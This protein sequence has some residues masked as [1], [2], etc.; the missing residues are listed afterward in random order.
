M[1]IYSWDGN[2]QINDEATFAAWFV[3][4]G[5]GLP[6]ME[7][8]LVGRHGAHPLIGGV[9]RQ[10]LELLF[11]VEVL[12][13]SADTLRAWFDSE[14]ETPKILVVTDDDGSNARYW[15]ALCV[16]FEATAVPYIYLVRLRVHG[17][18]RPRAVA[19][20]SSSWNVTSSGATTVIA[21]GTA[22]ANDN[23]YPIVTL[24]P[25]AYSVGANSYRRFITVR[26]RATSSASGYPVDITNDGLDTRVASTNFASATGA[27][28][29]VYVDGADTDFWLDGIDT[30]TTKIF[31]TLN[32]S[33]KQATTL[34]TGV[35]TG[36]L[37]S[38]SA[39]SDISGFPGSGILEIGSE[40]FVYTGKDNGTRT[41]SGVTRAAKG[42]TAASHSTGAAISWIQHD[43][44]IEYGSASLPSYTIG[45]T[46]DQ[47][48][49]DLAT[50][51][52]TSW[53][54]DDFF[55]SE[56]DR[57]GAWSFSNTKNTAAYGGNRTA[58]ATTYG[59]MGI[60]S[61][62]SGTKLS[63]DGSWSLFNPCGITNANFQNG[64]FYHGRATWWSGQVRSSVAGSTY[65]AAYT[66]P[67]SSNDT[68]NSW[69]QNIALATGTRYLKLTLAGYGSL[70]DPARLE[71]SDVTLTLNSSYTPTVTIGAE[72]T[73][74]RLT[75]TITN[76]TTGDAIGVDMS[77]DLDESLEI[78]TDN[79]EVTLLTDDS[80][81]YQAL[82]LVGGPRRHILRLQPGNNTLKYEEDGLVEVDV[83]IEFERR[84]YS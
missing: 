84:Y 23:A 31:V 35:G 33:A 5:L 78:D 76:E 54:Y 48:I 28:L 57:P 63:L 71:V 73:S 7:A 19:P 81:Q 17:D 10:G 66:I 37:S 14:D 67:T 74:Y 60:E 52:N 32:W 44:W 82:T 29:R 25:R 8:T 50:S 47:P 51:T 21:N 41:F 59:E 55:S 24:T 4:P 49:F 20:T 11:E 68:W 83:D 12:D 62:A 3:G 38:L 9:T 34:A 77:I 80:P 61:T 58:S 22:G 79:H 43:I 46:S 30:A 72:Q 1:I 40:L 56:G 26:W 75:A 18:V 13:G 69:S 16:L 70:A 15:R 2:D 6:G 65:V 53:N 42:T 64:E 36:S 39:G 27:D 45:S